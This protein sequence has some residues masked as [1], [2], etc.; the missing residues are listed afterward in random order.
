MT[1]PLPFSREEYEGRIAR[2][3][4]EMHK[5]RLKSLVLLNPVSVKYLTGY[6]TWSVGNYPCLLLGLEGEPVIVVWELEEPGVVTTS[7]LSSAAVYRTGQDK[8]GFIRGALD[9]HGL[10]GGT[11]GI[12]KDGRLAP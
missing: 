8:F 7:W 2:V 3:R 5:L 4:G 12:E 1:S 9:E 11:I 10:L 6:E